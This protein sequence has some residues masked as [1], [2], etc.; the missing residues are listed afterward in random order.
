MEPIFDDVILLLNGGAID[1]RQSEC[2]D[3]CEHCGAEDGTFIID[4]SLKM[5]VKIKL[6]LCGATTMYHWNGTGENPNRP[7][8]FCQSCSEAHYDH[9]DK[10]WAEYCSSQG[11]A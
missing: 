1:L 10:M 9:W 3:K 2:G 4:H 11:Y 8:T 7:I 6:E 5:L